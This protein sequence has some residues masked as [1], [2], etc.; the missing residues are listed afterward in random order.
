[1]EL[2]F[3]LLLFFNPG[4]KV[5]LEF[6]TP[7]IS[8]CDINSSSIIWCLL[9]VVAT[10]ATKKSKGEMVLAVAITN[11]LFFFFFHSV[12]DPPK[13]KICR[14]QSLHQMTSISD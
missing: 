7:R 11:N 8:D 6:H 12:Q 9:L 3:D 10:K 2:Y 14:A 13:E 1:M 4:E 5:L